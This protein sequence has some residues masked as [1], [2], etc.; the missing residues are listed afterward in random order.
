MSVDVL[1][2]QVADSRERLDRAREEEP[3]DR[4][5]AR[6][7]ATTT[8]P[9]FRDAL[10]GPGV[11]LIAEIKRGSPSRGALA[12]DLDPASLAARYLEGGAA[13]VSVLTAP[14]GFL[15][16]L[17]DLAAVAELG[18]PAL[19]K[20]FL[21]HPYQVWEARAVG[22]A[23]VLLLAVVLDDAALSAMLATCEEAGLDALVEVHDEH[24]MARVAR[25]APAIVGINV[26]DLRDFSVENS[27][28][29]SVAAGRPSAS[30]LVAESGVHGPEDVRAYRAAGAD[31]ILVGEHLVT[32]ADPAAAARSLVEAGM[33]DGTGG[34]AER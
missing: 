16:T 4:L 10:A 8:P 28:F 31:A 11:A 15:G 30:L 20:D 17:A 24:E 26:R 3:L 27:R 6:A 7:L 14:Q 29:A 33:A 18:I 1:A 5:R 34:G 9:S 19:R 2:A 25:L 23:A 13:A 32:S 22:A 12:P 21:V